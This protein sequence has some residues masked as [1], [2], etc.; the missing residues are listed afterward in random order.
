MLHEMLSEFLLPAHAS[1]GVG[2]FSLHA[3]H[4]TAYARDVCRLLPGR[5]QVYKIN[6]KNSSA[7][8]FGG[9]INEIKKV[10]FQNLHDL[11]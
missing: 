2:L 4:R 10:N 8:F 7:L 9:Q 11:F 1:R 5:L 6:Q 3:M